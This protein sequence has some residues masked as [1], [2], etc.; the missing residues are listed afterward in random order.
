MYRISGKDEGRSKVA[1][2]LIEARNIRFVD[3]QIWVLR[4][5]ICKGMSEKDGFGKGKSGAEGKERREGCVSLMDGH[6]I[7]RTLK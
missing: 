5:A 3:R 1:A 7:I 6:A 2:V 4:G